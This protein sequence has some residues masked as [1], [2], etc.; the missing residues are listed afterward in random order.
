[1]WCD[2]LPRHRARPVATAAAT[3]PVGDWLAVCEEGGGGDSYARLMYYPSIICML[4]C[5]GAPRQVLMD[6]LR[7]GWGLVKDSFSIHLKW[8]WESLLASRGRETRVRHYYVCVCC[9]G[10]P[11]QVLRDRL[12]G[13]IA[14]W[15]RLRGGGR[16]SQGLPHPFRMCRGPWQLVYVDREVDW[17]VG[18]PKNIARKG[19]LTNQKR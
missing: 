13:W 12:R 18:N 19:Q 7:D 4:R 17:R 3:T 15:G 6:G 2:G 16:G 11:R 9:G 5:G 8:M 14:S 1:M 10:A